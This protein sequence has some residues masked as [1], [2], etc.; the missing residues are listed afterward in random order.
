MLTESNKISVEAPVGVFEVG[1]AVGA[2]GIIVGVLVGMVGA[3][4]GTAV[5]LLGITL[6]DAEQM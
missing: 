4:D 5:G 6:G 1:D 2:V 3:D